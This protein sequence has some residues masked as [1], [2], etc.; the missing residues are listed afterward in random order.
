MRF[1][2]AGL[3]L[4]LLLSLL[5]SGMGLARNVP[6]LGGRPA[7]ARDAP[8]ESFR[9]S[10]GLGAALIPEF[11]GSDKY[12]VRPIP[13]IDLRYGRFFLSTVQGLGFNVISTEQWTVAPL[14]GYRLG[15]DQDDSDLLD[16]LGDVNGGFTV[17]G[18][19]V[20]HPQPLYF[21]VKGQQGLGTAKGFTLDLAATYLDRIAEDW[22]YSLGVST[23]I[24]DSDYNRKYF[25]ITPAQSAASD[26]RTYQADGGFKHWQVN[27]TLS[28]NI[29]EHLS[30]S[31][32]GGYRRLISTA[33]DSPLVKR[34]S[35][36]QF[37]SG[38]VLMW[39][40]GR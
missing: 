12:E 3:G 22:S 20:W 18:M 7:V 40:F 38:I 16:G 15:R 37:Q 36:N 33:A 21:S 9:G 24:A 23:T 2:S 4:F 34:G 32:N 27:G 25:S 8:G 17:G 13:V 35:V 5:A 39:H 11:E 31:L 29:T 28:Y 1:G 19:V 14:L 10:L 30:A 6:E 26:Y